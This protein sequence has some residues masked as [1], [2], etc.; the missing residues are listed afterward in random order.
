M[1][2][3]ILRYGALGAA[4]LAVLVA[5]LVGTLCWTALGWPAAVAGIVAGA[6]VYVVGRSY[7]EIVQIVTE[8][9]VP[10]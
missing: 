1:L 4:M 10:H 9:L 7:V 2:R 6:L 5:L 8:M 3:M